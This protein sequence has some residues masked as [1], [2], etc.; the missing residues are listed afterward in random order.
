MRS[1]IF[2]LAVIMLCITCSSCGGGGGGQEDFMD[3]FIPLISEYSGMDAWESWVMAAPMEGDDGNDHSFIARL[4]IARNG[5]RIVG[6]GNANDYPLGCFAISGTRTQDNIE[7]EI[8]S[9]DR[10]RAFSLT[11]KGIYL[12]SDTEIGGN[13][14]TGADFSTVFDDPIAYDGNFLV[15]VSQLEI[16]KPDSVFLGRI[17]GA[18]NSIEDGSIEIK[19]STNGLSL[20]IEKLDGKLVGQSASEGQ[21]SYADPLIFGNVVIDINKFQAVGNSGSDSIEVTGSISGK[22]ASGVVILQRSGHVYMAAFSA[23]TE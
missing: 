2:Y 18:Y 11:G 14:L 9:Q 23:I 8:I 13:S 10:Y 5:S 21:F 12:K 16:V 20:T 6:F 17:D 4:I 3:R 7:F 22:I 1:Y 15:N 19:T